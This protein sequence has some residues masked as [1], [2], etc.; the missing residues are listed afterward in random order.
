MWRTGA[1]LLPQRALF[2]ACRPRRRPSQLGEALLAFMLV[3]LLL[4]LLGNLLLVGA[5]C[6]LEV[7]P[8]VARL[9]PVGCLCGASVAS[10]SR[11]LSE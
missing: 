3:S 10:H 6:L 1:G 4:A 2:H 8:A 7:H 11:R 9:V 5:A